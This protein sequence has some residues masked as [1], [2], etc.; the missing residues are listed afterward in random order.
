MVL[1][2]AIKRGGLSAWFNRMRASL[3]RARQ[4]PVASEEMA[5][6]DYAT[7]LIQAF[8]DILEKLGATGNR[9]DRRC[10]AITNLLQSDSHSQYQEGL[11]RLGQT[12]GYHAT[13]PRYDTATD[14]RWRG[15][16]GNA[17]EVITFEA[18]IE[19]GDSQAL[20]ARDIGQAHNQHTR[21]LAEYKPHG[22]TVRGT[23]VTHLTTLAREAEA[24][25]GP[26]R[27]F[28]KSAI[29]ALWERMKLVLSLYRESWSLHDIPARMAAAQA[30]YPS[31]PATGWLI[32][33]IDVDGRFITAE[34]LL[35]EWS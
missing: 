34:R 24:S 4:V 16:F 9:F 1:E 28:A 6:G 3:H 31:L 2:D 25:A 30:I 14:C 29:F 21:A 7:H 13:R 5:R 10:D 26:I 32:R 11:E 33:A 12:L 35:A 18:K 15:V 23:I 17:R 22:Y 8:D 19:H 20:I 27:V